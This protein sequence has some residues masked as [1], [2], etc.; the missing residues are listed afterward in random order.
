[1]PQI[2]SQRQR[3]GQFLVQSETAG[4]SLAD[5]GNLQGVGEAGTVVVPF[6]IDKDLGL[7]FQ[8]AKCGAVYY[9]VTVPLKGRPVIAE[10][11]WMLSSS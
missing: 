11:L 5:L 10:Y 7:V 6:V 8:A 4:N 2:V 3:L 1:M 9:P